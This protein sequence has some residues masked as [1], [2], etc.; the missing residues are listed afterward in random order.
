MKLKSQIKSPKKISARPKIYDC[1]ML[2]NELDLLELRLRELYD[3]V[4]Y[5]VIVEAT[6]K[7]NG[8]P[9]PLNF[10]DNL[11]RFKPFLDKI[12]YVPVENPK[13]GPLARFYSFLEKKTKLNLFVMGGILFKFGRWR[14]DSSQRNQIK[15]GLLGCNDD[16][17]ILVSDLDEIPNRKVLP[18]IFSMCKKNSYVWLEQEGFLYYLNGKTGERWLGTKAITFGNLKLYFHGN[19]QEVRYGLTFAFRKKFNLSPS[20]K[21]IGDGGWHFSYLGG[22]RSV[23]EKIGAITH[24]E[25]DNTSSKNSDNV[26]SALTEG[27]S[28][29]DPKKKISYVKIDSSFPEVIVLNKSIFNHLI[30]NKLS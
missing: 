27:K 8:E 16:D 24:T 15:R 17:L 18:R 2:F 26:S 14:L 7:H 22:V 12:I 11:K 19:P 23:I 6:A 28:L 9:K 4:D 5:F 21:V 29:W 30:F 1:F 3:Y 10:R 25:H 20:L 13:L